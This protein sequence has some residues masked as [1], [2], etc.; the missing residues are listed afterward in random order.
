[1][2][3]ILPGIV[4][5]TSITYLLDKHEYVF[6][7]HGNLLSYAS[8]CDGWNYRTSSAGLDPRKSQSLFCLILEC[9]LVFECFFFLSFSSTIIT[10]LHNFNLSRPALLKYEQFARSQK[11]CQLPFLKKKVCESFCFWNCY[12]R[13]E[14]L[15]QEIN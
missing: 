8:M 10:N 5:S 11:W 14:N 3:I 7:W 2:N 9:N 15:R 13:Y 4:F 6:L 12:R 1:M